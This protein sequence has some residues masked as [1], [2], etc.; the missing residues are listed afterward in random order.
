MLSIWRCGL[1]VA[2]SCIKPFWP[3]QTMH[4]YPSHCDISPV[5]R[6]KIYSQASN[7]QYLEERLFQTAVS[8]AGN[9]ASVSAALSPARCTL[10]WT[11]TIYCWQFRLSSATYPAL[12]GFRFLA[13]AVLEGGSVACYAWRTDII[14]PAGDGM[15]RLMDTI[16][17][18]F[19][20]KKPAAHSLLGNRTGFGNF[21]IV[22]QSPAPAFLR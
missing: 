20:H 6:N 7:Y 14:G 22:L 9:A 11:N 13:G 10:I 2:F 3:G 1:V 12:S 5:G 17:C 21:D 18:Q 4:S 8:I 15:T 19:L 16:P